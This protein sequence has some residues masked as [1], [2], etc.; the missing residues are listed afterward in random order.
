MKPKTMIQSAATLMTV[1]T[2]LSSVASGRERTAGEN[3]LI[4]PSA[5]LVACD[6]YFSIWSP[7]DKLA[8]V[9]TTHWTGKKQPMTSV[10]RIDGKAHRVMGAGPDSI[11]ALEQK[12]VEVLPTR[13]I[14]RF[15]GSGIALD[16]TFT[17]PAL[18]EDIALLSRPV[19]YLNY[20]FRATD[21]KEHEVSV[22][23]G[24][25]GEVAVNVPEQEVVSS[26]ENIDG[27]AAAKIGTTSQRVLSSKGD[28]H[29]IDW[30][31]CYIA[32]PDAATAGLGFGRPDRFAEAF[33]AA[34]ENGGEPTTAAASETG[35]G[36]ALKP[37]Q[38]GEK[39]VRSWLMIAYDDLYSIQYNRENLR[40]YWRKD[41]WEAKD[42]LQASA[43][44]HESLMKR[45]EAFDSK[46]M[47]DMVAIGGEQYAK[48][49]AL[50]YRQCFAAG[51]FTADKNGQPL[52]FNKENHSNG[53]IATSDVFY[54]MAPQFL[55]FGSTVAKSFIVPF[56]NY[57]ASDRWKF[58]F[59]P[60]DLGTYPMANGQVYG[61]GEK[62]EENQMPV[63]ESGNMVI[64][65][66]AVAQMDGNADFA[67]LYWDRLVQWAAYLK[68]KGFDPENQLC[69]DDFSGHLAHNV[70]L[71]VK[72]ICG[73]GAFAKLCEMR[74]EKELA[75]EYQATA[76]E[77]AKRWMQEAKDG[78]HYRLAFDRPGTWSQKYNLIWDKILGLGLFPEEVYRTEMDFYL[79]TQNTYGLPLDNRATYTKLDWILWSATLTNRKDFESL[80]T[81]VFRFLNETPDRSPMT[82]WYQTKTAKK[83]GFTARSVVGGV[84]AK[85][86]YDE[87]L[88]KKYAVQ[89][90]TR[91]KG[92]AP[93]PDY[94]PPVITKLAPT[95]DESDSVMWTYTFAKPG[96]DWFKVDFD[97]SAWRRAPG[98]FG[99]NGTPHSHVRTEW[100]TDD[101]WM[102]RTITLPDPLPANLAI[103]SHHDEDLEVYVNGSLAAIATGF[104][105]GYEA[106]PFRE[107]GK[108]AFKP[109][110]NVIAVR[111]HQSGGGQYVDVS[112]ATIVPGVKK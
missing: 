57:A 58:P 16:L 108:S 90:V 32:A 101:I 104:N 21:G 14:Y 86:L 103:I 85:A 49:T 96:D 77:F 37:L 112:V 48:I 105:E 102:R 70:N 66:A 95:A 69:T 17:T 20:D 23:F 41:G 93:M 7:G 60:H 111:C 50:A 80:V 88:W 39:S 64:L 33:S 56:M 28:D 63:E 81:P 15:E 87:A 25:G 44:E 75:A 54:P 24:I 11:P 22:S 59:A 30:G 79:K 5:P 2:L 42:L 68:D 62:T 61:G 4:P 110:E 13:T 73:I 9:D 12:S 65:M 36:I 67:G 1:G 78:D 8:E 71:S 38:V 89:D 98:G 51:K 3:D 99:T 19:T 10:V 91:S 76:R 53:C 47:K 29:R 72:A 26:K 6:P 46:L 35:I 43:K 106:I 55:L 31:Y 100:R 45:C 74:G 107:G 18:P 94:I 92:W 27:L 40:P 52:Q 34:P 97:D 109:G 84:F 83:V 82:D